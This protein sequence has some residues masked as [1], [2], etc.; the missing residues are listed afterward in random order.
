MQFSNNLQFS[1][2]IVFLQVQWWF[3]GAPLE[4]DNQNTLNNNGEILTIQFAKE[5]HAGTYS[6]VANNSVGEA[7]KDFLVRITGQYF[8]NHFPN[9]N[10]EFSAPPTF[11][12]DEEVVVAKVGDTMLLSCNPKS[13]VPILSVQW[14]AKNNDVEKNVVT[15]KFSA[16]DRA[17][18]ITNIDLEDDGLYYCSVT[19]EAGTSEK[20][21]RLIVLGT[22]NLKKI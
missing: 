10:S 21:F 5:R 1:I 15:P 8:R 13:N 14:T 11:D 9:I 17:I 3:N 4:N 12:K 19:N 18:N 2:K 22:Q 6:C 7:K 20:N 16:N